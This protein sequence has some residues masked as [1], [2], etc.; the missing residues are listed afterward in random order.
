MTDMRRLA[1]R[2][3]I[4]TGLLV[5]L[6]LG[7]CGNEGENDLLSGRPAPDFRVAG[8]KGGTFQPAALAGKPVLLEFWAPWCAGCLENIEVV[9]NLYRRFEN[10][11]HFIAP[12]SEQGKKSL[13]Y[14]VTRRNITYPVA[15]SNREIID[16]YGV[17]SIPLTVLIDDKGMIRFRH[18]GQIRYKEMA[19]RLNRLLAD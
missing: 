6:F 17:G 3:I 5:L 7:G 13:A 9:N 1:D 18:T 10:D 19:D 12:S 8:L 2:N 11:V 14:F 16:N 4:V 15:I